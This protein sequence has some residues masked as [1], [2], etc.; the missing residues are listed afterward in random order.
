MNSIGKKVFDDL[1]VHASAVDGIEHEVHRSL[2]RCAL[3]LLPVDLLE[4]V[5]VIKLNIKTGR[6]SLLEYIDFD[7]D[8]FP[9]L[10]AIMGWHF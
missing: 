1:Y 5:S 9:T 3:D 2:I 8:P 4:K 10:V 6:I 7:V